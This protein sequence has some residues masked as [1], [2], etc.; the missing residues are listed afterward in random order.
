MMQV[1]Y[2]TC[3][4]KQQQHQVD[5]LSE[6][7]APPAKVRWLSCFLGSPQSRGQYFIKKAQKAEITSTS[8]SYRLSY[9]VPFARMRLHPY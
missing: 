4:K 8:S 6:T 9:L 1:L 2:Y 5:S 3:I 7:P